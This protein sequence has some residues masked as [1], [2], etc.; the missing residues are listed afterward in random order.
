MIKVIAVCNQ[1]GGVGKTTTTVD[2]GAALSKHGSRVLLVDFDP[3][4]NLSSGL[5]ISKKRPNTIL[6]LLQNEIMELEYDIHDAIVEHDAS[7]IKYDIIPANKLL[8]SADSLLNN[9]SENKELVLKN[10]LDNVKDEYDYILIDCPPS[11]D[12]LTVNALGAADK[13][14][15][16]VQATKYGVDGLADLVRLILM[17]QDTYNTALGISGIVFTIDTGREVETRIVKADVERNFGEYI[18]ILDTTIPRLKD[19]SV[20]PSYG[21]S[22]LELAP[23]SDGAWAYEKLAREVVNNG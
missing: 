13:V 3:Q 7:D 14:L 20:A 11:L 8:V 12:K 2:L 18:P 6:N 4:G 21:V 1:K 5:G 15:I 9:I 23:K 19:I 22:V 10:I 16:T 17:A